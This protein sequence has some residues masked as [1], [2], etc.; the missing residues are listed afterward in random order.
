MIVYLKRCAFSRQELKCPCGEGEPH[1]LRTQCCEREFD[2]WYNEVMDTRPPTSP[3]CKEVSGNL[4]QMF[5]ESAVMTK[6]PWCQVPYSG[7]DG[8]VALR[9][10]HCRNY[11]CALCDE[12]CTSNDD[13]HKHALRCS[14][15]PTEPKSYYVPYNDVE[16]ILESRSRNN[17][18]LALEKVSSTDGRLLA[19]ALWKA[20]KKINPS[21]A[22]PRFKWNLIP[23]F[24]LVTGIRK[25]LSWG[26]IPKTWGQFILE[27]F[28][29]LV[30]GVVY[31][32]LLLRLL[33]KY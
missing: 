8:C 2:T 12:K 19:F 23:G 31:T 32:P 1:C 10:D 33:E 7:F 22:M 3:T 6:C 28:L 21:L 27:C 29:G 9:C 14:K 17:F 5:C 16:L 26:R 18:R 15:N 20:V 4:A 30:I 13:A 25:R 11:F 24:K